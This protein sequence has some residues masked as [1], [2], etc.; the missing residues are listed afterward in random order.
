VCGSQ[1]FEFQGEITELEGFIGAPCRKCGQ[2]VTDR[3]I[4]KLK[5][6]AGKQLGEFLL[7]RYSKK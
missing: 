6:D 5:D 1:E 7:K 3:D 2:E 4:E